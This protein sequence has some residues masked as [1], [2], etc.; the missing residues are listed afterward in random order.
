MIYTSRRLVHCGLYLGMMIAFAQLI[1]AADRPNVVILYADD[2]GYG[3]F[4]A[5][6]P[7]SSKIPT[8]NMNRLA[9]EGMRFTDAHSSSGCCSPSRYT[10]LTADTIGGHDCK[11]ALSI[12]G[13]NLDRCQETNHC[14]N[15][16]AA[17]VSNGVHWEVASR[18][19]LADPEDQKEH[20]T[21]FGGR[22][23][24][25][26]NRYRQHRPRPIESLGRVSSRRKLKMGRPRRVFIPTS[27][28]RFPIGPLTASF[29][30]IGRWESL[31]SFSLPK[32]WSRNQASFSGTGI[33]E[34]ELSSVLQRLS[35]KPHGL[36]MSKP[37]QSGRF[38]STFH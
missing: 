9:S 27:E 18:D 16:S 15:G 29:E 35:A 26:V 36:S 38:C 22:P 34:W 17:R 2:L 11:A 37:K 24:E 25:E 20:F 12:Y 5:N 23:A 8:P 33:T 10:L 19:G 1:N 28:R 13:A 30:T 3:D 6:H 32:A 7:S 31:L 14:Q 4:Q 21:G